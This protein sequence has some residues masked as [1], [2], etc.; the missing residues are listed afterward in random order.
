M[1][2]PWEVRGRAVAS[3]R[4]AARI[5]NGHLWIYASDLERRPGDEAGLV[6]VERAGGKLV[7]YAMYSPRSQIALRFL[8]IGEEVPGR[9]LVAR[10]LGAALARRE[11]LLPGA[12]AYR[13]VH[14]EADLLPGIFVDRYADAL[15]LQTSS[16]AADLLEPELV[17][18]LDALLRPRALVL[19]DDVGARAREGLLQHV[20]VARGTAPV[21]ATYREGDVRLEVDLVADQKTGS[22]LDQSANHVLARHYARGQAFDGFTYH[23]G[24]ALQL[25]RGADHVLAVDS[26]TAAVARTRANAAANGAANVEVL[27]A[28]VMELLPRLAAERRRF[29]TMVLDPPAF[30]SGKETM[31]AALRAYRSINLRAMQLLVPDGILITCSC[32]GRITAAMF[33]AML[34]AAA[35]D[36]HRRL[37]VIERRGAGPDHPALAGMP[38]TEY[39]KCR[40][41]MVL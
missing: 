15:A 2:S 25:A 17:D 38:E 24:F 4:G 11:R 9:D 27:E 3:K 1:S 26:S 10:R 37:H 33:D 23:G 8:T 36:A 35:R 31:E 29:D 22:F 7:G 32:S 5:A 6:A 39:L 28:N 19:R 14:G 41:L 34:E 16:A 13:L 30:A 18:M 20:T 21:R 40:V 12:D